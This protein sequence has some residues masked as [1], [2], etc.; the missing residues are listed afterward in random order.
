M[1]YPKLQPLDRSV[2]CYLKAY[3]KT[4][5]ISKLQ[6]NLEIHFSTVVGLILFVF[7]KN[8]IFFEHFSLH[9]IVAKYAFRLLLP[10]SEVRI[11]KFRMFNIYSLKNYFVFVSDC[12]NMVY[13]LCFEYNKID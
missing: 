13:K 10:L 11:H 9:N 7:K 8:T 1:Q 12:S 3:L 2:I 6:F 5:C 4:S